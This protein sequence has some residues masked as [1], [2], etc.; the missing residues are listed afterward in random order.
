MEVLHIG[1]AS[2]EL[3]FMAAFHVKQDRHYFTNT[4]FIKL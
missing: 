3:S 4:F 1:R 2:D